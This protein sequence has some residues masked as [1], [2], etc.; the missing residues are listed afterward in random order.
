MHSTDV[1]E[2]VI[3]CKSVAFERSSAFLSNMLHHIV[4]LTKQWKSSLSEAF[5]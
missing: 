1:E 3:F 2:K 5:P 4:Q